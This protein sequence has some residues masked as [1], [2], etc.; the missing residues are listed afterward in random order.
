MFEFPI[1]PAIAEFAPQRNEIA[2]DAERAPDVDRGEASL[3]FDVDR[4][5]R[6]AHP[7]LREP[8]SAP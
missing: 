3:A 5:M 1:P 4:E 8:V 6:R 7:P 2:V